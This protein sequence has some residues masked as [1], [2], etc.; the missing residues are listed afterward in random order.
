MA[1]RMEIGSWSYES[2]F[3]A[4][5]PTEGADG[6]CALSL[7]MSGKQNARK[8]K[9]LFTLKADTG[10]KPNGYNVTKNTFLTKTKRRFIITVM[11][12]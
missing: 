8:G 6:V 3:S 4:A 2:S 9:A 5:E 12:F 11:T 10:T 1:A 7:N